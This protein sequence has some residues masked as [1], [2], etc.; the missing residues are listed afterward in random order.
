M[1]NNAFL[2]HNVNGPRFGEA[3]CFYSLALI[4]KIKAQNTALTH[5]VKLLECMYMR[6]TGAK[7]I[8]IVVVI[9]INQRQGVSIYDG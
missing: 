8:I 6:K 2:R 5:S 3:P 1:C 4:S 7:I 9:I